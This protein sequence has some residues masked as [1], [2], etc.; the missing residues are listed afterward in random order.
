LGQNHFF[1]TNTKQ[2]TRLYKKA[3]EMAELDGSQIV[4]DLYCGTGT[5]SNLVAGKSKKV[6]GIELIPEAID[7]ATE[8]STYNNISNTYFEAADIKD[9]LNDEFFDAHGTPD[10]IITDPPRS[11]MHTDVVKAI[12]ESGASKIVYISCNPATQARDLEL[13]KNYKVS[14]VQP[15]DMFPHTHHV[16]NIVSLTIKS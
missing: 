4:Y 12:N 10:V 5:I 13:L 9:V 1:Q 14:V 15:I 8:N 3:I 6:I 2:A 7:D 11:G 16:E